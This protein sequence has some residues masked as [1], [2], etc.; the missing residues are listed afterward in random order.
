LVKYSSHAAPFGVVEVSQ[1]SDA[2]LAE[3]FPS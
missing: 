3:T 1:A 2:A